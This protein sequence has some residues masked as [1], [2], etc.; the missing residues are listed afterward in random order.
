MTDAAQVALAIVIGVSLL[1]GIVAVIVVV[2]VR[3]SRRPSAA[4][5]DLARRGFVRIDPV[6]PTDGG[7]GDWLVTPL[8]RADAKTDGPDRAWLDAMFGRRREPVL[9]SAVA[10]PYAALHGDGG[11][12]YSDGGGWADSGGGCDSGG[13]G[14]G[15]CD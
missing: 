7:R 2:G 10:V 6:P 11:G 4:V 3:A 14:G 13:D 9:W 8:R 5:Q 1:A 15:G 12:V